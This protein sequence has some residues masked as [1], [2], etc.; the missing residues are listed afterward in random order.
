MLWFNR[1]IL[2]YLVAESPVKNILQCGN[3][4]GTPRRVRDLAADLFNLIQKWNTQHLHGVQILNT[5]MSMKL[6][7]L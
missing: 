5:I 4:T 3:L 7:V 2:Y 6:P 1:W